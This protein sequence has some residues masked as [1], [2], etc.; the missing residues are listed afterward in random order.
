[1][2]NK[3]LLTI[4]GLL[5]FTVMKAQNDTIAIEV[6]TMYTDSTANAVSDNVITNS[7]ALNLLFEKL[8]L[9]EQQKAGKV[10][11]VHVGDSH[12]QADIM[13]G[14]IRR[15]LQ[16]RFGNAGSGFSF[17][18]SLAK[19]NGSG[20]VRYSSNTSWKSRRNIYVPDGSPVGLSGISLVTKNNFAVEVNV[21]D[22]SYA[23]NTLKIITPGNTKSFE[24]ATSAKTIVLEST[25]PKKI[26][27]K[28]KSGEVLGSIA[29]K[30]NVTVTQLKK[31]NGLKN[32]NIRAGKTLQ[33]PTNQT[34]A[35]QVKKS[36][37]IPLPLTKDS[38]S[39]F[40]YSADALSKIYLLPDENENEYILSG[41]VFEKDDAG[42]LYHSIGVNGAKCSD[43]NKYPLFFEQLKALSPDVIVISL[44]TN[45]SFDKMGQAD[46]IEKLNLF[47]DNVKAQNPDACIITMT[48]PPSQF[49]RKYPNTFAAA[50]AKAILVQE[51]DMQ[52]ASWDLY[53]LLGGLYGVNKNYSEGLIG[54]DRVHYTGDGY[55]K[56][57]SLF[58][59]ALLNAYDNFKT[60]RN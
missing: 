37:F 34:Q 7:S 38:L 6:T 16:Q 50:Y 28:I 2:Q 47:I 11:I 9:L 39:H 3:F 51:T 57:G 44:G 24:V 48:P 46:Y 22:S 60:N 31:A 14:A 17:P 26:V 18:H 42:L 4:I 49:K 45:E 23:F 40:F 54:A 33:I 19:T 1:M 21:R 41:L 53:S 12:I 15:A 35:R 8:L 58:A 56:Q 52:Y 25:V 43:Y 27:H 30:Y 29:D 10:N 59:E 32:N 20:I 5:L 36:E 13:T 55:R